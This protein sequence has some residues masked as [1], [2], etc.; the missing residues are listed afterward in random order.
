MRQDSVGAPSPGASGS[1]I[2][3]GDDADVPFLAQVW[4]D[5]VDIRHLGASI[6]IGVAMS[7]GAF[8]LGK[9]LLASW[10]HDHELAHAGSMLA[11]LAGCLLAGVICARLFKPKRVVAEQAIDAAGRAEVLRMLGAQA[12]G[13]GTIADLS[14]AGRA[15]LEELGILDMFAHAQSQSPEMQGTHGTS[16]ASGAQGTHAT[17]TEAC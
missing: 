12:G 6:A 3:A 1:T 14:P 5:T 11:G 13:I 9:S 16:A 10:V 17:R 8:S 4:G 7:M 2:V 15:E